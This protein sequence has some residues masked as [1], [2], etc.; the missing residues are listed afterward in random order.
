[1]RS[2]FAAMIF[3]LGLA[4]QAYAADAPDDAAIRAVEQKQQD[5]WNAHDAHA[6][7]ALFTPGADTVNVLGW[8]W[9][10]NALLETRLTRAYATVFRN[11]KLTVT[12]VETRYLSPVVAVAHVKWTMTGAITP[13]G[14]PA[15]LPEQG[16]Q[17]QVLVKHAGVWLIDAFQNTN[18]QPEKPFAAPPAMPQGH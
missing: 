15:H 1:M 17:T 8:W 5:A 4:G 10:G 2:I 7:A 9:K 16:I 3:G 11:S 18:S 12:A 6:Y 13:D 14:N